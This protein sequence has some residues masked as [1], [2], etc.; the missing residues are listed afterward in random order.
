MKSI[1]AIAVV[2]VV[3]AT[4]APPLGVEAEQFMGVTDLGPAK[5]DEC[6]KVRPYFVK[7]NEA[8]AIKLPQNQDPEKNFAVARELLASYKSSSSSKLLESKKVHKA[9]KYQ[10]K[11]L[12]LFAALENTL[13]DDKKCTGE[14]YEILAKNWLANDDYDQGAMSKFDVLNRT[15]N[16]MEFYRQRHA[17]QCRP[18]YKRKFAAAVGQVPAQH[19]HRV[20]LAFETLD[21]GDFGTETVRGKNL[22][23]MPSV[24]F[25][26]KFIPKPGEKIVKQVGE[27]VIGSELWDSLKPRF[28]EKTFKKTYPTVVRRVFDDYLFEPCQSYRQ[29]LADI[30][31]PARFDAT[32][33]DGDEQQEFVY[34]DQRFYRAMINNRLCRSLLDDDREKLYKVFGE[35]WEKWVHEHVNKSL[36]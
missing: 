2:V 23:T 15:R 31:G 25:S 19:L 4:V 5:N 17:R 29:R 33:E 28:D 30:L 13:D 36:L 8:L 20:Q 26:W 27:Q 11:A 24:V 6:V 9:K 7:L 22:L 32:L 14:S 35:F 16:I 12:E 1:V 21:M 3:V 34:G 18:I 10:R